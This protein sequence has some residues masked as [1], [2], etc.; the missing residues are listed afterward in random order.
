MTHAIYFPGANRTAQW[1]GQGNFTMPQISKLL[2]HTTET[3][4]WPGYSGGDS[5][6]TL[7]VNPHVQQVRQHFP[8]NGSARALRD[9][10][11]TPVR[12]NRDNIVQVEIC[13]FAKNA[14]NMDDWTLRKIAEIAAFLNMEWELPI[15][16]VPKWYAYPQTAAQDAEQ[17][18]SS[19]EFDAYTGI[20]AHMHASGNTHGDTGAI[21]ISKI[22]G[23]AQAMVSTKDDGDMTGAES[24]RLNWLY[25][26]SID[27]DGSP[28]TNT[29]LGEL[30]QE[31]DNHTRLLID[32]SKTLQSID[33]KLS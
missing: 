24:A 27:G 31:S 29:M 9:P 12:E 22:L 3:V 18:M 19:A 21:N 32:I 1:F 13:W 26:A 6:P 10:T 25:N 4:G 8:L 30:K 17:R 5:A 16:A 11:N 20:L 23:Y 15:R 28:S 2:L 33:S 14:P 7:T